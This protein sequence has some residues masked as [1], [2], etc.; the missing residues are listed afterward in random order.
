LNASSKGVFLSII[1]RILSFGI[2]IRVSTLSLSFSKPSSH[3]NALLCHSNPKGLV[4]THTTKAPSHL[5]ISAMIGD[6]QVPVQPHI[7][8]VMNTISAQASA[9]LISSDDSSAA[10]LPISGL[11]PAQSP[12]VVALQI[13]SLI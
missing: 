4:T 5:A 1:E 2:V 10:F 12:R 9:C 3:W 8:Q 6:A 11:A 7:P 13:F